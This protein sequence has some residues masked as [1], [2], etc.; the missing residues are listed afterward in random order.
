[1]T[2]EETARHYYQLFN[3]RRLDAAAELVD[4]H[5]VFH[6]VPT[7]QQL[8]G[9]DGYRALMLG[10][11]KAF[12]DARLEIQ[13]V[14]VLDDHVVQVS[15]LGRG[16]H[17]GDLVLGETLTIPATGRAAELP[18]RTLLEIRGGLIVSAELDFDV[19]E[20]QRR[21]CGGV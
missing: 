12:E 21:L 19:E 13:S 1:M 6:Y 3:D 10:W 20:M 11:L 7:R 18:F 5:A 17:T 14:L 15:Y 16:T 2:A 4:R 9:R 8:V